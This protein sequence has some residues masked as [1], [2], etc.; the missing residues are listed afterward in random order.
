MRHGQSEWNL[1]NRFTGWVDVDL[2][3]RGIR[4]A[5]LAGQVLFD[6]GIEVDRVVTSSLRRAIRTAWLMLMRADQCW[7]PLLKNPDLNE[8]HSGA[9]TG[10]NKKDLAEKFGVDQVMAWRR[11]YDHPPHAISADHPLQR[12]M[13]DDGRY[14]QVRHR[15]TL[16]CPSFRTL[17]R[18][19]PR[20]SSR[21]WAPACPL[22]RASKTHACAS[23]A[24]GSATS[25]R[26]CARARRCSSS[27]TATRCAR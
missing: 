12:A 16:S 8:Q 18:L 19:V 25:R 27:R 2:T 15:S 17:S 11:L 4:E 6:A 1:A 14:V 24:R 5:S 26:L 20:Y 9:L 3:E 13:L 22:P 7:V 23:V 21:S 10:Q